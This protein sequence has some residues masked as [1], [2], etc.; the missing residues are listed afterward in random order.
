MKETMKIRDLIKY[1]EKDGWPHVRTRGS[2]WQYKHPLKTG[3]DM[4]PDTLES[5]LLQ[6]GLKGKT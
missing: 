1:I 4:Y 3:R 5:V 2:H 6:A